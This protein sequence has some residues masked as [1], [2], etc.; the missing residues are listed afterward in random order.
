MVERKWQGSCSCLKLFLWNMLS[1]ENECLVFRNFLWHFA[2]MGPQDR[3]GA[4]IRDIFQKSE[5]VFL[6]IGVQLTYNVVL[7][8]GVQQSES[9]IHDVKV[10]QSC[11]T[12]CNPMDCSPAGSSVHGILQARILEWVA[13]PFSRGSS[14]PRHR[15]QVSRIAG[16][17]FPVW[18]TSYTYSCISIYSFLQPFPCTSLQ[19]TRWSSLCCA[20]GPYCY[21]LC[22]QQCVPLNPSL[23]V[24]LSPLSPWLTITLFSASVSLSLF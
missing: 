22:A 18:A 19:S 17:F 7:V 24:V 6:L 23:P 3:L 1:W 11:L 12:L 20:V 15:T 8:S 21:L 16:G 2:G 4:D 14:Q 13:F 10:A 5:V 9:V